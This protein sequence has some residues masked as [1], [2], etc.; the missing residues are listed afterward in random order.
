[1]EHISSAKVPALSSVKAYDSPLRI[2][3]SLGTEKESDADAPNQQVNALHVQK[4]SI[5]KK[6]QSIISIMHK[7]K[8]REN[9]NTNI[10]LNF[11]TFSNDGNYE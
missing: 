9:K 4:Q 8:Q 2:S 1:L 7:M 6:K 10:R 11:N 5:V 3:V